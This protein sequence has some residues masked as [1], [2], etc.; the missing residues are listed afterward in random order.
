MNCPRCHE[1]LEQEFYGPCAPCVDELRQL[2]QPA[3]HP[4]F[5]EATLPNGLPT[6]NYIG[7]RVD[8][9]AGAIA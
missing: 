1:H 7:P 9:D 5:V 4:D 6:T 2:K 3:P 8:R